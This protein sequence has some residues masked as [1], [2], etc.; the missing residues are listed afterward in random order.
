VTGSQP[1]DLLHGGVPQ[2]VGC[3]LVETADGPAL[4]DCGPTT[5][6]PALKAGLTERGLELRDIRHLLLSHIHFDHAGATGALVRENP[7]L[8]VHVSAVGAPH[9]VEP[10][11][12]EA[13]A[14]R[15]YGDSFDTLW[16]ELV[17][18]PAENIHIAGEDVVGL[19][20]F[21]T[22]G[23]A[24][25]H[26][27]MLHEDGTLYAGDSLGVRIAPSHFVVAP[28]PPPDIDLEAWEESIAASERRAPARLAL[29][30]FGVFDDVSEHLA[31]LRE[32]LAR[33]ADR[34]AHGMDEA[35]FVAA[36]QADYLAS[37]PGGVEPYDLSAPYAQCFLGLERYWRKRA[38]AAGS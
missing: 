8:H 31:G 33:W 36:A 12:L 19:E 7:A 11:R 18:V 27:S 6:L 21:P 9:L 37:I 5:C 3:Y 16:G 26:I 17:P 38:E 35:T 24:S 32:T 30:H 25:H 1:I 34:V 28:T 29:T 22:P 2:N 15:L 10:S 13:S 23:H 20:C 14:R 4:Y